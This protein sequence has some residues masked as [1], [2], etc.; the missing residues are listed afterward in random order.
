MPHA[1]LLGDSI[2]DNGAYT[3]GGPAVIAQLQAELPPGWKASLLAVDG[4]TTRDVP[5]QVRRLPT[6]ASHL[7]ASMGGNDA[8]LRADLLEARVD[9]SAEAF[10]LLA[11]A[12]A[13]FEADYRAA[14]AQLLATRLPLTLCTI[15]NGNFDDADYQ[16]IARTALA[17]FND[18]ILRLGLAHGL[19][20]IELRQVCD[21]PADFA[22]PIEPSSHGGGKI[23]RAIGQ[24]LAG[25]GRARSVR[26]LAL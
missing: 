2:L 12:L 13:G 18:V 15:Y 1:I 14:L 6:D 17:T 19:D 7:V 9:S 25:G 23:A 5:R 3:G 10:A 11:A 24:A 20:I 26:L 8:L 22:N 21:E 4:A 16:R